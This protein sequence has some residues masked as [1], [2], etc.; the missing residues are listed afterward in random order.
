MLCLIQIESLFGNL[1]KSAPK[2]W[3][4]VDR[5]EQICFSQEYLTLTSR[6]SLII[7]GTLLDEVTYCCNMIRQSAGLKNLI[8]ESVS[9]MSE[10]KEKEFQRKKIWNGFEEKEWADFQRILFA[11]GFEE[12]RRRAHHARC[13]YCLLPS[14]LVRISDSCNEGL[15]VLSC[16]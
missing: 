6:F 16:S 2:P 12:S 3:I 11:H 1:S 7:M 10:K 9:K 14:F 4:F 5:I 13:L 15:F 8:R